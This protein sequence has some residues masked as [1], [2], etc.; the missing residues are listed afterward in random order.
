MAVNKY[1]NYFNYGRE[2]DLADDLIVESIKIYG[3]DVKYMPRTIV[4]EDPLYGEASL[5]KFDNAV[6][7]EMYIKNTTGF[8]GEGDFLSKFNLEIRDTITFTV[9]RKRWDQI[10]TEKMLDEVGYN[11]Q[12]ESA[13]TGAYSNSHSI[14]VESGTANGY[15]ISSSRPLEGDLIY[16]PLTKKLYEIKFVE[17]EAIFY[18]HGKLYT[19]DLS[20]ELFTYS[21]E[22]MD[23]GN[24]EID[25]IESRRTLDILD[26]Q[27]I[28]EDGDVLLDES[29]DGYIFQEYRIEDNQPTANNEYYT[30]GSLDFIDF[31]ERNP[32]S[33]RDRW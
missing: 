8:E 19:Y 13:N 22:R 12:L 2:Q 21:S 15:S 7:L 14:L 5:S 4:N 27:Y 33:E 26:Q 11:Y 17:H 29:G 3:L 31:S 20:C 1:F 10:R 32:F 24:T 6:S 18:Q 30:Q 23:T 9:A 25:I 16:F 28:F